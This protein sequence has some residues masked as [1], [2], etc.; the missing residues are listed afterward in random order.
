VYLAADGDR[1]ARVEG[2]A[3]SVRIGRGGRVVGMNWRWRPV[4]GD[5]LSAEPSDPADK[6]PIYAA[7]ANSIPKPQAASVSPIVPP[8]PGGSPVPAAEA[9]NPAEYLFWLADENAPQTFLAPVLLTRDDDTAVIEAASAH[10]LQVEIW[11]RAADDGI[12]LLAVPSGGSGN[13][14]YHWAFWTHD[15]LLTGG[16]SELE[17]SQT[18]RVTA[19]VSNV[20]VHVRDTLTG[21]VAQGEQ[22]VFTGG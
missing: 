1:T 4:T 17:G 22:V 5:R 14:E 9:D 3:I 11:Q 19:G 18:A 8:A 15:S 20:L 12:E 2:A 6:N 16:L 7:S 21:A 13:Y 10:S